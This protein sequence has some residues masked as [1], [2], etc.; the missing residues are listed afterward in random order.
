MTFEE[1]LEQVVRKVLREELAKQQTAA[2][3]PSAYDPQQMLTVAQ[4]A[5]L[6][7]YSEDGVRQLIGKGELKAKRTPG[8]LLVKRAWL[9]EWQL[10]Q[11]ADEAETPDPEQEADAAY[12]RLRA[13]RGK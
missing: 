2:N 9:E 11:D 5:E 12:A 6:I 1:Q 4:V 7:H 3:G 13:K 10:R 8:K